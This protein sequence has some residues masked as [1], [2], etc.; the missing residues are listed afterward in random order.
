MRVRILFLAPRYPAPALRGD[1]RRVLDLLRVLGKQAE[2]TLL[3]FGA[4]REEPLP[5][6]GVRVRTIRPSPGGRVWANLAHPDPRLPL[7]VRLFLDRAMARACAEEQARGPDAVHV[8]RWRS[9]PDPS[10]R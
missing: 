7:Q 10:R 9:G 5:F 2:V 6:D 1:Q 4:P 3:S 8:T